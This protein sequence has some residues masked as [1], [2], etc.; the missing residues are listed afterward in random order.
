MQ[1]PVMWFVKDDLGMLDRASG[2]QRGV[3]MT[4]ATSATS[5]NSDCS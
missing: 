5:E 3:T 4:P 1:T 2:G